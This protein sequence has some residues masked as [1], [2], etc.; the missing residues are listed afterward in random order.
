MKKAIVTVNF[1]NGVSF[2][3]T[4]DNPFDAFNAVVAII[5][6]PLYNGPDNDRMDEKCEYMDKIV[7]LFKGELLT[8]KNYLFEIAIV[9]EDEQ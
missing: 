4:V 6:S 2:S 8:S 3:K 7:R 5:D 9:D 1:G